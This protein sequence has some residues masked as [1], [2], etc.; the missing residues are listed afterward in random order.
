M[1][2]PPI[3][4]MLLRVWSEPDSAAPLRVDVRQTSDLSTGFRRTT[5]L[6]DVDAVLAT[7]RSFL[8]ERPTVAPRPLDG[9][10]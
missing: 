8:E 1:H 5:T 2:T 10:D 9:A 7:V 6:A 4:L 3:S